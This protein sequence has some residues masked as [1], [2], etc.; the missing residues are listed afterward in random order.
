[1]MRTPAWRCGGIHGEG[2]G[3]HGL[4]P[5][6]IFPL[7]LT[8]QDDKASCDREGILPLVSG[9]NF[10]TKGKSGRPGGPYVSVRESAGERGSLHCPVFGPGVMGP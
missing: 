9:R 6:G 2:R 5:M 8:N 3:G 10:S 1:V 7:C 4:L